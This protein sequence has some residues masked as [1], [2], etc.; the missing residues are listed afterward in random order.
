MPLSAG[1]R[2]GPYEILALIGKGGMGEV[3][4]ARDTRLKRYVALKVLPEAFAK[5]PNRMMRFQREAEVLASL[6]HPNIAQ[7]Y[8]VEDRA[9]AM[10]LVEGESPRGP[11][12]FDEAW[13]I[14]SQIAAALSYA[15]EKGVVHRDLKPANIKVTPDGVVKLL[16]FGLAKAF[17]STPDSPPVDPG[18]S[19]TVTMGA[20]AV[21]VILGTAAYM[22]PEQA[23]GKNV[24]RRSDIWAFGVVLYE[25]LTGK[26]LFR[27]ED[28]TDI[29]AS[30]VKEHHDLSAAPEPAQ[31]VLQACLEKDPKKRLQAIGDVQYLV[32][33]TAASAVAPPSRSRLGIWGW[34]VAAVLALGAIPLTYI[35]YHS[36]EEAPRVLRFT[37]P[38]PEQGTF[39]V[40]GLPQLSPDGRHIAY[41]ARIQGGPTQLWVRDLDSLTSRLLIKETSRFPFWSPDSRSIGFGSGGKLQKVD[42]DGGPALTLCDAPNLLGGTWN[43]DDV[44]LFSPVGSGPILRVSAAGGRATPVTT[45]G[46]A[47]GEAGIIFPWFFPDGR[48]FLYTADSNDEDKTA[49]YVGDL[50][51]KESRTR[52]MLAK[53]NAVY[54]PPG[55]ILF[56][57]E[58]T[59]MA[60][61][62][63]AG[64]LR[65]NGD[66][67]PVAEQVDSS[68]GPA[69]GYFSASLNGILAFTSGA[70]AQNVQMTWFD[71]SGKAVG[72]V[73]TPVDM[74]WPAISPDGKTVA[75]DRRDPQTGNYDIW[76]HDL[77]RG[78]DSRFTFNSKD[79]QFPV[80]SP[81]GNY[82]AFSF[83]RGGPSSVY[84]KATGGVGREEIVDKDELIKR[85]T[86]WSPD[87]RLV[88]EDS[89]TATQRTSSDIWI[90]P[91]TPGN[92]GER[93]RPYLQTEFQE[94]QAKISPNGK[95]LAYYSNET[96][97]NEVYIM[98]F[99]NPGGKWQI[100][101]N[102]GTIPIWSRDG[103]QLFY[104]NGNK[105]M[106]VEI[107]GT[108][109]TPEPGV[110]QPL[111]DVRL[112]ANNPS[113]DVSKDGRFLIPIAV[114]QATAAPITVVVNWMA[115]LRK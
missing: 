56:L 26:Q 111:F 6:N 80:W 53:S 66:A 22:S 21:G 60:L 102:G 69:R 31:R 76:L 51:S 94:G 14:A 82:L 38:P 29:L 52:V 83:D 103:K 88:I 90:A 27:G 30:V 99:P 70:Q 57:R 13:K 39:G 108:G 28:L 23:R 16:D 106:E 93:P 87:G 98:T 67:V 55:Y 48:H 54:V 37:V 112:G 71:R 43:R 65:A 110:P 77:V 49:I 91:A 81:D 64:K 63:D 95:W 40:A 59:L 78:N 109:T 96:K 3:Y 105:M 1:T 85:P 9:L 32:G 11:M 114:E 2:L 61:P 25:L 86:D 41:L 42:A 89:S 73:G 97:R 113:F 10:E 79:N 68:A 8:G 107:K 92:G 58:H 84:K 34:I 17:S 33:G 19:P 5:D 20:T 72:T 115:G 101:T 75:I 36:S 24:D 44:I 45:V 74:E 104:T 35:A 7:I 62:F 4:R 46:Q 18:N 15:H 50:E 100:S 47:S 12:P